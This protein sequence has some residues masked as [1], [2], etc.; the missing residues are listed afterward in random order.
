MENT[1]NYTT[2][3]VV[4]NFNFLKSWIV[5]YPDKRWEL[6]QLFNDFDGFTLYQ[7]IYAKTTKTEQ[8]VRVRRGKVHA[9][10]RRTRWEL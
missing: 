6:N 1:Q 4:T 3:Q 10:T 2:C 5:T 8:V 7:T 9:R